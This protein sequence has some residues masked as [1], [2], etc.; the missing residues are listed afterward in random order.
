MSLLVRLI[1]LFRS[2][3]TE[4]Q[5]RYKDKSNDQCVGKDVDDRAQHRRLLWSGTDQRWVQAG[6]NEVRAAPNKDHIDNLS[7]RDIKHGNVAPA[8]CYEAELPIAGNSD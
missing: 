5:D 4:Q 3:P 2:L 7:A 1:W 6:D 8:Q